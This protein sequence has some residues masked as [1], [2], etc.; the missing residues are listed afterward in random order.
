MKHKHIL[1]IGFPRCGSTWLWE[2][3]CQH[4]DLNSPLYEKE[5]AILFSNNFTSYYDFYKNYNISANFNPNIWLIDTELI[6]YLNQFTTHISIILRNPYDFVERYYDFIGHSFNHQSE[7]I[8]F[9]INQPHLRY[10]DI[11]SR[12]VDN[13]T[14]KFSIFYFDDIV[15]NSGLFLSKYFEFCELDVILAKDFGKIRNQNSKELKTKLDFSK[16]QIKIINR[17]IDNFS[18]LSDRDLSHWKK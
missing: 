5:N 11:C 1:N 18:T 15:T 14:A 9:L 2:N 17:Q 12:W 6:K 4:P 8:D 7:F 10:Y 3:L 13:S 16:E